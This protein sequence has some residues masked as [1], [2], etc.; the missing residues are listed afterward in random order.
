MRLFYHFAMILACCCLVS[1]SL[2]AQP[3]RISKKG[4]PSVTTDDKK[5]KSAAK[6]W[7]LDRQHI[8][9]LLPSRLISTRF[10]ALAVN[11]QRLLG[12]NYGAVATLGVPLNTRQNYREGSGEISGIEVGLF[13]RA[14]FNPDPRGR[15]YVSVGGVLYNNSVKAQAFV[16]DV[17]SPIY[18]VR[19]LKLNRKR[20]AVSIG[21]G[22]QLMSLNGLTFDI[23]GGLLIG[24]RGI[25]SEN[26]VE[27]LTIPQEDF[28]TGEAKPP[29]AWHR[30]GSLNLGLSIGYAF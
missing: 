14:Y 24:G 4:A 22:C 6:E 21:V 8:V 29:N 13:A 26:E 12:S 15:V 23:Q 20:R 2:S 7:P 27:Y 10:P 19:E 1:I 5:K 17:G 18:E 25:F 30:F 16:R 3:K 28:F 9:S 11:Y